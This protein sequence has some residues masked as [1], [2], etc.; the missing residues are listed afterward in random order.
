MSLQSSVSSQ[1]PKP[2]VWSSNRPESHLLPCTSS[3]LKRPKSSDVEEKTPKRIRYDHPRH[4]RL[5]SHAHLTRPTDRFLRRED[6]TAA[7]LEIAKALD[8]NMNL[9]SADATVTIREEPRSSQSEVYDHTNANQW[10]MNRLTRWG[11]DSQIAVAYRC[12]LDSFYHHCGY[13]PRW[14]K[15]IRAYD[16]QLPNPMYKKRGQCVKEQR[17]YLA[18]YGLDDTYLPYVLGDGSMYYQN[19]SDIH[20]IPLPV[21]GAALANICLSA[22]EKAVTAYRRV[23]KLLTGYDTWREGEED[24]RYMG[25]DGVTQKTQWWDKSEDLK[26]S[27]DLFNF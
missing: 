25:T 8:Q 26:M 10:Q 27:E 15:D 1:T 21:V 11:Y 6:R 20:D 18:T 2:H 22:P 14:H 9:P 5:Y 23:W 19:Q 12:F 3:S 13:R 4:L 7:A 16:L 17:E 24:E